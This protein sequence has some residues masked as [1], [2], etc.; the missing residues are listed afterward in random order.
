MEHTSLSSS[1][2]CLI[3]KET[4]NMSGAHKRGFWKKGV[5]IDDGATTDG[6]SH[7][8]HLRYQNKT[9]HEHE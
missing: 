2:T 3:N 7:R 8:L 4:Q 1:G 5:D 9:L 6:A